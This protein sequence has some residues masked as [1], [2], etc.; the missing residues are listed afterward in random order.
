MVKVGQTFAGNSLYH[1]DPK[2]SF[3]ASL[4]DASRD[5]VMDDVENRESCFAFEHTN[6]SRKLEMVGRLL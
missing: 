6:R 5:E 2:E 3:W 1:E 4:R